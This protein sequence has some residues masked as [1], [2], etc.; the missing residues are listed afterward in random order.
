M[1]NKP[2]MGALE[3]LARSPAERTTPAA[4]FGGIGRVYINDRNSTVVCASLYHSLERE[5]R[6]I[7][8]GEFKC[9]GVLVVVRVTGRKEFFKLDAG[10]HQFGKRHDLPGNGGK[11]GFERFS[12]TRF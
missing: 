7:I 6:S 8:K 11:G 2:A 9:V 5:K 4:S 3:P 1:Q 10:A 12:F